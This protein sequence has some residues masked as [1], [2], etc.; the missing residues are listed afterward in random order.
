MN[1]D[2]PNKNKSM[3]RSVFGKG[4]LAGAALLAAGEAVP[5]MAQST[6]EIGDTYMT[7]DVDKQKALPAGKRHFEMLKAN[8]P[9]LK[10]ELDKYEFSYGSVGGGPRNRVEAAYGAYIIHTK[11]AQ[12]D[13]RMILIIGG[14]KRLPT[15]KGLELMNADVLAVIPAEKG[16]SYARFK[17]FYNTYV[18]K[19]RADN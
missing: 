18:V 9:N 3:S 16:M 10:A 12:Y 14:G 17:T 5:A 6:P 15:V 7:D 13:D 8:N 19:L 11:S 1:M 4:L 2:D